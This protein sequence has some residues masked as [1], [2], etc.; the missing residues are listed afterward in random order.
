MKK[1]KIIMNCSSFCDVVVE[2]KNREEAISEA[3]LHC[4][5]PQNGMEFGEFL[6]VEEND[7]I[8]N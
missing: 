4:N 1:Y 6:E 7:E 5:C 3:E 2:A 8:T